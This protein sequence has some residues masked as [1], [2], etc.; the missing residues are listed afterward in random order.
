VF[1]ARGELD[2]ALRIRREEE[3]PVYERLGDVRERA[4]TWG[5]I[6]DV[7][8]ARGELDEALHY[9]LKSGLRAEHLQIDDAVSLAHALTLYYVVAWRLMDLTFLGRHEPEAPANQVLSPDEI[10]VLTAAEGKT[11]VTVREAVLAIARQGG[12]QPYQK[13]P[14]GLRVLWLGLQRVQA[15]AAGFRLAQQALG[16]SPSYEAR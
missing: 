13:T 1:Q 9:T 16:N 12:Y 2:E 5:K 14:P 7:F 15:M 11:I 6:A 10:A 3:L 8:Q 4:V